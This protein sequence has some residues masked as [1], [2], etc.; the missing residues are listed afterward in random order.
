MDASTATR[1]PLMSSLGLM[2]ESISNQRSW[3]S[4]ELLKKAL[5]GK[6]WAPSPLA[7]SG[8]TDCYQPV[9]KRLGITR[10]CLE[11]LAKTLH[12]V[13]I[14]TK[15]HL[16]TRDADWLGQLASHKAASVTLSIT[17]LGHK[18]AHI[19]E[20]RASSPKQRLQAIRTLREAGVPVS[21]N[22]APIIPGLNDHEIP[23]ILEAA[24]DHGALSAGYTMV[25]LPMS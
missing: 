24:A 8:V 23:S 10:Q 22:V 25:R 3:S 7:C 15:N 4:A 2:Q 12:P 11:V 17:T 5:S 19:L 14:I 21:G 18:L 16:V 6:N 20:P 9:E 1:G 13:S